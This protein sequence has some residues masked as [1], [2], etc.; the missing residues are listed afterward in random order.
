M[1]LSSSAWTYLQHI[2]YILR[3][4]VLFLLI[5]SLTQNDVLQLYSRD[6]PPIVRGQSDHA[7]PQI[8]LELL[9][10][11]GFLLSMHSWF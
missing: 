6:G 1:I 7:F 10:E 11:W 2:L 4:D 9:L 8:E 3:T 5:C